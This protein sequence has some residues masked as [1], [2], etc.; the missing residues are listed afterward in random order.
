MAVFSNKELSECETLCRDDNGS[1][2]FQCRSFRHNSGQQECVLSSD[3][4]NS[5]PEGLVT[6]PVHSF[7]Q[8]VCIEGAQPE[9]L[10]GK[11]GGD[12]PELSYLYGREDRYYEQ[13]VPFQRYRK[14]IIR[15]DFAR[16]LR[17]IDLGRCLDECLHQAGDKC[18]SVAYSPIGRECRISRF[19]QRD[20]RIL[21]DPDFDYYENLV[22]GPVVS[23]GAGYYDNYNG[24][25]RPP[26][27]A[28]R[29]SSSGDRYRGVDGYRRA[30]CD[31]GTGDTFR[32][33][34]SRTRMRQQFIKRLETVNS[35]YECEQECLNERTFKCLSFNYISVGFSPTSEE[36]CELSDKNSHDLDIDNPSFY[37]NSERHDFYQRESRDLDYLDSGAGAGACL[38]VSQTCDA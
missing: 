20:S 33:V 34:R 14:S 12:G 35:L 18:M 30:R 19:D 6:S 3:D 1:L 13:A 28:V 24:A 7:Y 38:D 29:P 8:M 4:S 31:S 36:N 25:Y 9:G 11:S 5:H 2:G 10:E 37:D 22:A 27:S 26:A 23:G 17:N 21:Y 16:T 15:A 32:Q